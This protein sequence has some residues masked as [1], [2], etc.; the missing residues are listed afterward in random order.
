MPVSVV[1]VCKNA[2][3]TI[4]KSVRSFIP[5]TTDIVVADTGSTDHTIDIL[6]QLPVHLVRLP[7]QGYGAT[8]NAASRFAKH[9]W[10]LSVDSDETAS[11][12]LVQSIKSLQLADENVVYG[13]KRLSYLGNKAI[14]FGDWGNDKVIRL[15]NRNKVTWDDAPVHEKLLLPTNG[16]C[17]WIPGVL[18]HYTAPNITDFNLKQ[19]RYARLMAAKYFAQNKKSGFLKQY[20]SPLF[21]FVN[22]YLFKGGILDGKAGFYIAIANARYTKMKYRFLAE[23]YRK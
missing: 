14:R 6:E 7:W 15:F 1:I 2:E 10:I 12:T 9:A 23:L 16:R 17:C 8:K 22:G 13:C 19:D 11:S 18:N 4:E 5:L 21:S 20:F 3:A